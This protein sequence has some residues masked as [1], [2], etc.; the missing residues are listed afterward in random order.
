MVVVD[1]ATV[2]NQVQKTIQLHRK[3]TLFI[4]GISIL[5][6]LFI[7]T[8]IFDATTSFQHIN[9]YHMVLPFIWSVLEVFTLLAIITL[10]TLSPTKK[11]KKVIIKSQSKSNTPPTNLNPSNPIESSTPNFVDKNGQRTVQQSVSVSEPSDVVDLEIES[12]ASSNLYEVES[13]TNVLEEETTHNTTTE[14]PEFNSSDTSQSSSEETKQQ[15]N[16]ENN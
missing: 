10:I 8:L 15:S 9:P 7:G 12:D 5:A 4:G 1:T 2:N 14:I 3:M 13:E 6:L 11:R 16:L